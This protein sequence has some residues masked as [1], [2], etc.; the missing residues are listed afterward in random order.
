MNMNYFYDIPVYRLKKEKYY[1]ELEEYK[2]V[3]LFGSD[4]NEIKLKK[5]FYQKYP[6]RKILFEEHL[7]KK[8]GGIWEFNEIIGI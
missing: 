2:K 8:F 3:H 6:D 7:F 4:D 5:K 1:K